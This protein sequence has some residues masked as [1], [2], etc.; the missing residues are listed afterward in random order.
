VAAG[1]HAYG[2]ASLEFVDSKSG[3]AIRFN[4]LAFGTLPGRDGAG[5]DVKD[6]VTIV[7]TTFR[8]GSAFGRSV[9]A[10]VRAT[11]SSYRASTQDL[12]RFEYRIVR[13]EFAAILAAAR[14]I[15]PALSMEPDDYF[16]RRFGVNQEV[17]G[18]GEIGAFFTPTYFSVQPL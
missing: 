17:Y 14:T 6:G 3:R 5:V 9:G 12:D 11:S 8:P 13:A 7:G 2:N 15:D 18:E 10:S 4:V 16:V 1:S